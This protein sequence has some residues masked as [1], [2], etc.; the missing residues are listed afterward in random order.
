MTES[1]NTSNRSDKTNWGTVARVGFVACVAITAKFVVDLASGHKADSN[2]ITPVEF[3]TLY[4]ETPVIKMRNLKGD[5][6][7]R[8]PNP[9]LPNSGPHGYIMFECDEPPVLRDAARFK[10]GGDTIELS[11]NFVTFFGKDAWC[12]YHPGSVENSRYIEDGKYQWGRWFLA[13][14]SL[15]KYFFFRAGRGYQTLRPEG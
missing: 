13:V 10:K 12:L 2:E 6:L 1:D 3:A 14:P 5:F 11:D 4:F 9:R 15:H 8:T 7:I